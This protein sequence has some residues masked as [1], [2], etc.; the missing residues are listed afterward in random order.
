MRRRSYAICRKQAAGITPERIERMA[1]RELEDGTVLTELRPRCDYH[2]ARSD[3]RREQQGLESPINFMTED[4]LTKLRSLVF[5]LF[6]VARAIVATSELVVGG[7][8]EKAAHYAHVAQGH[9]L[10]GY[11]AGE[12]AKHHVEDHG[13]K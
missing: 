11:H 6:F 5:L 8:H 2:P 13:T 10:H 9:D 1:A 4:M 3:R 7:T 12:A